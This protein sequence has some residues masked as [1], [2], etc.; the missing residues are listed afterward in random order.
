M[1]YIAAILLLTIVLSSASFAEPG[2]YQLFSGRCFTVKIGEVLGTVGYE[3]EYRDCLL[4]IDTET[5]KVW[6]WVEENK[7]D[8]KRNIIDS[9]YFWRELN[10]KDWGGE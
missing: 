6:E 2:K 5:G 4:K 1:K 10:D 7:M 3:K 8:L 9:H